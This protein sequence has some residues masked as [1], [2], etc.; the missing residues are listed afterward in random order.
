MLNAFP[1]PAVSLHVKFPGVSIFM[2]VQ[3]KKTFQFAETLLE[4]LGPDRF[5]LLASICPYQL[6]LVSVS[7]G[8]LFGILP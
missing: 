2:P 7:T 4:F 6:P 5:S 1:L 3:E 8:E